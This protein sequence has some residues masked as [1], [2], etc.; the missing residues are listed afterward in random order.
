MSMT[1]Y[2]FSRGGFFAGK[3]TYITA[4]TGILTAIGAYLIGEKTR[5]GQDVGRRTLNRRHQQNRQSG[6]RCRRRRGFHQ[7]RS[8]PAIGI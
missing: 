6:C 1:K 8:G 2:D 5:P 7:R 4:A 3:K